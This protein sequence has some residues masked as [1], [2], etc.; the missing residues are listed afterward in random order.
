MSGQTLKYSPSVRFLGVQ[1]DKFML[2]EEHVNIVTKKARSKLGRISSM[3]GSFWGPKPKFLKTAYTTL[4]RP[5]LAYG[6]HV[7]AHRIDKTLSD[8]L[9]KVNRL[10]LLCL[11]PVFPGTPTAG[12]EIIHN[13]MPLDIFITETAV[14][15]IVR[16]NPSR[17]DR[18]FTFMTDHISSLRNVAHTCGINFDNIDRTR[19]RMAHKSFTMSTTKTENHSP[20]G[21]TIFT[22]GSKIGGR[23]GFGLVIFD[24]GVPIYDMAEPL[25]PSCTVFQAELWALNCAARALAELKIKHKQIT[26]FT[27][28]MSSVFAL[29]STD[30]RNFLVQDTI[31]KLNSLS[32]SNKIHLQWTKAH[33]GTQGNEMADRLAKEGALTIGP[34]KYF[35]KLS[36]NQSKAMVHQFFVFLWHRRWC[37]DP[38]Y[39]QS[40]FWYPIP[41]AKKSAIILSL[42]RT[43]AAILIQFITGFNNLNHHSYNKSEIDIEICRLCLEETEDCT[44]LSTSCPAI[45]ELRIECFGPFGPKHHWT[46]P[47]LLKFIHHDTIS[48]LLQT[49]T[50]MDDPYYYPN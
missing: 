13:I 38:A 40:R 12:L 45:N 11:T 34:T 41:N 26:I 47:D 28:S 46:V 43:E 31:F 29:K 24:E 19:S 32:R 17:V 6:C 48:T 33:V 4:I 10:A 15:T 23:S 3:L 39:R 7:W 27:D 22:D 37:A 35:Q 20:P 44:H 50:T 9:K 21:I 14:N 1:F 2:F 49:R 30:C 36:N 25:D 42:S 5:I 8:L 16:C 18:G